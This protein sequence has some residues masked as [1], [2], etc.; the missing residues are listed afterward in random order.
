MSFVPSLLDE[1]ASDA[2]EMLVEHNLI[3]S[4]RI[5]V[6][7]VV[8]CNP[9]SSFG[10]VD[11]PLLAHITVTIM[12]MEVD[13]RLYMQFGYRCKLAIAAAVT[14]VILATIAAIT[15]AIAVITIIL[16]FAITITAATAKVTAFVVVTAA[17]AI[18]AHV[19]HVVHAKPPNRQTQFSVAPKG[20]S[21]IGISMNSV[22]NFSPF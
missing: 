21:T 22:S 6:I 1:E 2:S 14:A 12:T 3:A 15:D 10:I 7:R 13:G 17:T 20:K 9:P 5:A 8:G 4:S 11:C 16:T 18:V 19:Q